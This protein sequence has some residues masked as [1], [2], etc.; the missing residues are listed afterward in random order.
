MLEKRDKAI[1]RSLWTALEVKE[2]EKLVNIKR[3]IKL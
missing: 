2:I 1:E 3:T